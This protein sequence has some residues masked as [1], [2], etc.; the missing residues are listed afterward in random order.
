MSIASLIDDL[1]IPGE[2]YV[3]ET[4]GI[5]DTISENSLGDIGLEWIEVQEIKGTIQNEDNMP[6]SEDGQGVIATYIGFFEPNFDIP[7]DDLG[8][9]RIKHIFP[10]KPEFVRY[11]IIRE[12]DR[13][14]IMDGE[15]DH[16]ELMLEL[17]RKWS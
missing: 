3:L 9:Y 15:L 5:P 2:K 14:L 1:T 6:A 10:S 17:S 16:Y 12:M 7:A 8:N 4:L 11:F 13:N